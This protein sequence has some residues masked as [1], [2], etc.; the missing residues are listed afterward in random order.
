VWGGYWV[1][2]LEKEKLHCKRKLFLQNS[3]IILGDVLVLLGI[4][5]S[6]FFVF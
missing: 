5:L 3:G 4:R 1:F 2:L 6:D